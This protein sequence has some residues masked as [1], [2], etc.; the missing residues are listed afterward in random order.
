MSSERARSFAN[1]S[2]STFDCCFLLGFFH[3]A[4]SR[5][6]FLGIITR[7]NPPSERAPPTLVA[8][9]VSTESSLRNIISLS[10]FRVTRVRRWTINWYFILRVRGFHLST[11][12]VFDR[13][14]RG[15]TGIVDLYAIAL[16]ILDTCWIV[17]RLWRTKRV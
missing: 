10:C 2:I 3:F 15:F 13:F 6:P 16:T 12:G 7:G 1:I 8:K 4:I 11:A 5:K 17:E 9:N 14:R